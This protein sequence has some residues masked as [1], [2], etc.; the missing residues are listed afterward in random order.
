MRH[1]VYLTDDQWKIFQ[2]LSGQRNPASFIRQVLDRFIRHQLTSSRADQIAPPKAE[3]AAL[4][5]LERWAKI[6]CSQRKFDDFNTARDW[7]VSQFDSEDEALTELEE[8]HA[9]E[10]LNN[11]RAWIYRHWRDAGAPGKTIAGKA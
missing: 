6:G 4:R 2:D 8:R 10:G 3:I 5:L 9:K 11:P 7:Y 1:Q